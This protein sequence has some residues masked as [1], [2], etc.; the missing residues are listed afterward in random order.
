MERD[1]G[2]QESF[3]LL[4]FDFRFLLRIWRSEFLAIKNLF[5]L[6]IE[7]FQTFLGTFV[8]E[9]QV[10]APTFLRIEKAWLFLRR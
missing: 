2:Q 10:D 6:V 9:V 5:N 8:L 3:N 7:V 1:Q 4:I